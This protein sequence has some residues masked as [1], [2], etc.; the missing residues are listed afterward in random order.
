MKKE[1]IAHT[2]LKIAKELLA[3]DFPTTVSF[4][5]KTFDVK[6]SQKGTYILKNKKTGDTFKMSSTEF[7]RRFVNK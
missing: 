5:G 7:E 1:K 3:L 6:K 2:L 4:N